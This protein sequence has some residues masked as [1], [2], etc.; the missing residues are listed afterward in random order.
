MGGSVENIFERG[1]LWLLN[2]FFPGYATKEELVLA[3]SHF[4]VMFYS[5]L[6]CDLLY[7]L[8]NQPFWLGLGFSSFLMIYIA[9]P[10]NKG[11]LIDVVTRLSGWLCGNLIA[12][13]LICR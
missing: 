1:G 7:V 3:H 12:V 11:R 4:A 8:Y 5:T 10:G 2:K 13:W 9:E 6:L